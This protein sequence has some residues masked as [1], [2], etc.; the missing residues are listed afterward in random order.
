[1]S[2]LTQE[3]KY[4]A[5]SKILK[6]SAMVTLTVS[7]QSTLVDFIRSYSIVV[8]NKKIGKVNNGASNSFTIAPGNHTIEM[9]IDWCGSKTLQ[10]SATDGETVSF[11]VVSNL[12][13]LRIFLAPWYVLFAHKSYLLLEQDQG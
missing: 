5:I 6:R 9:K 1:M 13:G 11:R 12:R 8:D 3:V 4:K 2:A 7:R 10:F